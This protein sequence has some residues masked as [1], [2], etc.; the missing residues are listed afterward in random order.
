MSQSIQFA[1]NEHVSQRM[2]VSE[3]AGLRQRLVH[4]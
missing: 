3:P 4:P 2:D 1:M